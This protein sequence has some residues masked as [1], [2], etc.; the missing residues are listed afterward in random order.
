MKLLSLLSLCLLIFFYAGCGEGEPPPPAFPET[1]SEGG[2]FRG[3][4]ADLVPNDHVLPYDLVNPLY[5]DQAIKSRFIVLPEGGVM[6]Y[7]PE[8]PF[9][10]SDNTFIIKNF[11]FRNPSGEL[12][13]VETRLMLKTAAG[14]DVQVYL[15]NE[16]QTEARPQSG[17]H[18]TPVSFLD[19][20]G[21]VRDINYEVPSKTQCKA[22]HSSYG[23]ILP[24]GPRNR[25][26]NMAADESGINQL[27]QWIDLG[28]L[29]D[30][31]V[32]SSI[33]AVPDVTDE[34]EAL[35]LRARAYLD[36]NCGHCHNPGGTAHTSRLFLH[37]ENDN[38][39]SLGYCKNPIAA[40]EGS[41]GRDFVIVPGH[42]DESILTFRMES[43]KPSVKMPEIGR[44][45]VD[46]EGVKLI[47]DWIQAM[48]KEDCSG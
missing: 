40:G 31:P 21:M 2:F 42:P 4:L 7:V 44:T 20:D 41:G 9:L 19:D 11:A 10:F 34:E 3:N 18:V 14:W 13:N 25:N 12:F 24:I 39:S 8:G 15:W 6:T 47:R 26:L 30:A 27:Q 16:A 23:E 33:P 28:I 43:N 17:I 1:L 35:D 29:E 37:L 45:T 5:S 48:E 22:C 38:K 46:E 36:I 32:L